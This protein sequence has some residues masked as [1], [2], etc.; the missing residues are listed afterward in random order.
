MKSTTIH[1]NKNQVRSPI[2][3][4]NAATREEMIHKV[5]NTVICGVIG[6]GIAACTLL[7]LAMF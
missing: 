2:P 5:L 1:R 6:A 3:Y 7:F 4:P